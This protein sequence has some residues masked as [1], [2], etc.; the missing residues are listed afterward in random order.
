MNLVMR[1]ILPSNITTRNGDTLEDDWPY[2]EESDPIGSY[3]PLYVDAVVSNPPYSQQWDPEGKD[4]DPRYARFGL[5]PKGKAD[6]AFLLHDLYHIKPDGIMA[7]VLPHGVLF[8][9]GEEGAIRKNLIESNHIDAVIGLP[10]N[11]FFGTGIPTIVMVLKQKRENTDV[12]FIDASKGFTKVGKN[13]MLQAS[14][15]K[16]VSDTVAARKSVSKFARVVSRDEIRKNEYNLNIPRYVDSSEAPESWDIYASMFGGIPKKEIDELSAYWQTFPELKK[17]LFT[18]DLGEHVNIA[19]GNVKDIIKNHPNVVS[20][21][22]HYARAFEGFDAE[23]YS[24][25]VVGMKTLNIS[26]EET[27]LSNEIFYRLASVPLV[28][29]YNAYQLLNDEWVK[30]AVDLEMVQTEG[31]GATKQVDPNM[32]IK[33]K[34]GNDVE[35]QEGWLGR[36][37]PFEIVQETLLHEEATALKEKEE[38]LTQVTA[39]QQEILDSLT[40]EEKEDLT[41]VLNDDNTAFLASPLIKM[42]K[43]LLKGHD[44]AD[45]AEDSPEGKIITVMCLLDE[46]KELKKVI[47]TDSAKLHLLTKETIE[48]LVD[49]QVYSLLELKWITPLIVELRKMPEVILDKL[50]AKVQ[51]LAEKYSITFADVEDKI[52]ET[53]ATL[54][55]MIEQLTGSDVDIKGLTELKTLLGGE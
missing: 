3:N 40:E 23:L 14:D 29:E 13:N 22:E 48:N 36:I 26:K 11:I 20:F 31:F 49:E 19:E 6:Y 41:D 43:D 5:A 32:V 7:I 4:T 53:E 16:R 39:E 18:N 34:N 38:R 52:E 10:A 33:K 12:L 21:K 28:D 54:S 35:V 46:E 45:Y 9:G 50:A 17:D 2:F 42:A 51:V 44:A 25:L 37:I 27:K 8:R 47:K 24:D 30:I 55:S 1:G 15:I